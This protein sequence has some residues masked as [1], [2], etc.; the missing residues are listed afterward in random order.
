MMTNI[1]FELARDRQDTLRRE[2]ETNRVA[3]R[4]RR[5]AGRQVGSGHRARSRNGA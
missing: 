3:R 5:S 2:A 1:D 4:T